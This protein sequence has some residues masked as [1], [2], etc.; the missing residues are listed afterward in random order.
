MVYIDAVHYEKDQH[1]CEVITKMK[2]TSKLNE[3]ATEECNKQ[4]MIKFFNEDSKNK[5]K[6]K[7]YKNYVW[8]EGEDVR[9]VDDKY[10]RT[11][12]NNTKEDNLGKLPR[13]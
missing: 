10:L 2:Y 5:A 6:T 8:V 1:G 3:Q 11:D 9:V 4:G 13:Y 7:C 12:A